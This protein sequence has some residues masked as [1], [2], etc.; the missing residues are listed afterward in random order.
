MEHVERAGVH[1]GD[2]MAVYPP[3]NLL[4]EQRDAIVDYTTRMALA[5]GV[6]GLMNVQYVIAPN[7]DP[8]GLGVFVIEVNPRSSR[9][10]PFISKVTGVP[11]VSLA[12]NVMLGKSLAEQGYQSGLEPYRDLVAVKAPVFSMSKLIGVDTFLGPEMKSTGEVMGVDHNFESALHKAAIAAD[13]AVP[14]GTPFLL[15]LSDRTKSESVPLIRALYD[16]G[17]PLFATEGTASLIRDLGLPVHFVTKLL[18]EG[19]PNVVDV[20]NAGTVRAVINTIEGG[21][22]SHLRDGFHIR[23][24]ATEM[25]IPCFTSLDTARASIQAL[26]GSTSYQV[27]PLAHYRDGLSY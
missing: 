6:H 20:I 26:I 25:R 1:S 7:A 5:L 3:Q 18:S 15:S 11:L 4:P 19:S 2:S 21:R 9:T 24:A 14:P 16:A 23:R 27:R 10:V 12:V 8:Q 17:S 22:A 13:L